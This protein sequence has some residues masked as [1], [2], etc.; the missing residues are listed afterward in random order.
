MKGSYLIGG[1][2]RLQHSVVRGG[3]DYGAVK[4]LPRRNVEMLPIKRRDFGGWLLGSR[5]V[6]FVNP[7][8]KTLEKIGLYIYTHISP[9]TLPRTL[10]LNDS[11]NIQLQDVNVQV[12]KTDTETETLI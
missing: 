7:R 5:R 9:K 10:K 4:R 8:G 1:T 11:V 12:T 2:W 3:Q 6:N